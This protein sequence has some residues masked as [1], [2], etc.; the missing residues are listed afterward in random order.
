M[1]DENACQH[2]E[3]LLGCSPWAVEAGFERPDAVK[4]LAAASINDRNPLSGRGKP[5]KA[6]KQLSQEAAERLSPSFPAPLILPYD[7]LN[8]D[9]DCPAQSLRSWL[10]EPERNKIT[11]ERGTIY[12]AAPPIVTPD[13]QFMNAWAQ[14]RT[15]ARYGLDLEAPSTDAILAYLDA[16]YHGLD[17]KLLP[18]KMRFVRWGKASSKNNPNHVGLAHGDLCIRI[19]TREPPDGNFK[20]QLNLE[21]LLDAAIEFLP[22]DAYAIALLMNFDMYEGKEDTFCCGRAY[23]GSRVCVVSTAR[24]HP[25]LDDRI[26]HKHM[27]PASHCKK[28]ADSVCAAEGLDSQ[29]HIQSPNEILSLPHE[30]LSSPLAQAVK[31]VRSTSALPT[32]PGLNGLWFACVARTVAHELGHCFGLDHCI[33]Y[34]CSMQGTSHLAEDVRQP[35]YLCPVCLEKVAYAISCELQERDQAGKEDY[36]K[37]RYRAIA[38]FC[39][40]WGHVDMFAAYHAWIQ[41]RLQQLAA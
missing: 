10:L 26:D 24:Y 15:G 30:I 36:I 25:S 11:T 8:W 35:P 34:A 16:F 5:A 32:A 40:S 12:V 20:R 41:A 27:W 18:E 6:V 9:P 29:K 23:G 7:E 13:V 3:L 22:D 38:A 21:D 1:A 4:R 14:P 39:E 17:V 19:R 28:Y 2:D 33:Y 37:Q 31:A